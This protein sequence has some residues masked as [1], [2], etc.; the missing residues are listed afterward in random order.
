MVYILF[1][2]AA[3]CIFSKFAGKH[4]ALSHMAGMSSLNISPGLLLDGLRKLDRRFLY[5]SHG[6]Y[7]IQSDSPMLSG[8]CIEKTKFRFRV[9]SFVDPL[10]D[11]VDHIQLTYSSR[12]LTNKSAFDEFQDRNELLDVVLSACESSYLSVIE[13]LQLSAF[14][15]R[16][17]NFPKRPIPGHIHWALVLALAFEAR[18]E[19][20]KVELLELSKNERF[21]RRQY[22]HGSVEKLS[23]ALQLGQEQV[24]LLIQRFIQERRTLLF[25]EKV[26]F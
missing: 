2:A 5:W 26:G 22:A 9:Y 10:F 25:G 20:A 7:Y 17:E 18:L 4:E 11:V 19:D 21:M 12:L 24:N 3:C 6:F 15:K 13:G 14:V 8:F 1:A 16:L 23:H